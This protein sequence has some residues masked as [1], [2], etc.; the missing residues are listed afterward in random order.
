MA[1][2]YDLAGKRDEA[3]KRYLAAIKAKPSE[4]SLVRATAEF[5]QTSGSPEK[6]EPFLR[7]LISPQLKAENEQVAWARRNL[8]LAVDCGPTHQGSMR[9]S[10][11]ST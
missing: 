9:P 10:D 5:Y 1:L 2:C 4:V 11:F 8:A 3:E 6:A 7:Q